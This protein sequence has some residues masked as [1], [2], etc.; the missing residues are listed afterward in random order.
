MQLTSSTMPH[1]RPPS[2]A[3]PPSPVKPRSP[4]EVVVLDDGPDSSPTA[5]SGPSSPSS[6]GDSSDKEWLCGDP[7]LSL[8]MTK[9]KNDSTK[10]TRKAY[11]SSHVAVPLA[12]S[13]TPK[14]PPS[15]PNPP[16]V[17]YVGVGSSRPTFSESLR[18]I[19]IAH[20]E[21]CS[22]R[23]SPVYVKVAT[24]LS[25]NAEKTIDLIP[26]LGHGKNAPKC[27][28][29]RNSHFLPSSY[30][31]NDKERQQQNFGQ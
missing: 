1:P 24:S 19:R 16:S 11:L 31:K 20:Q 12:S 9:D 23:S 29:D 5:P 4:T 28:D 26:T 27:P 10:V 25:D 14:S 2:P 8:A 13:S 18:N 15:L 21:G 17:A 30:D 3:E 6:H 22:W 7:S